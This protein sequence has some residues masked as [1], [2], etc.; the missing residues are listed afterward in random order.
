MPPW[1]GR[2]HACAAVSATACCQRAR[3]W[4]VSDRRSRSMFLN[5]R[6]SFRCSVRRSRVERL[7]AMALI[8]IVV[9]AITVR[10]RGRHKGSAPH[11]RAGPHRMAPGGTGRH[12]LE[13]RPAHEDG[14]GTG[15]DSA[16]AVSCCRRSLGCLGPAKS[17]GATHRWFC[18]PYTRSAPPRHHSN[19]RA[20]AM[21]QPSCA[22]VAQRPW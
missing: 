18:A 16:G 3:R 21:V 19:A 20:K 12:R 7:T 6:P 4:L 1:A 9:A 14:N 11:H 5:R 13:H 10:V 22:D 2:S 15:Q 8:P 17:A